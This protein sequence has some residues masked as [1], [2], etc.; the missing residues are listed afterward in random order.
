MKGDLS[1]KGYFLFLIILYG[2]AAGLAASGH[3][4]TCSDT[5]YLDTLLRANHIA[6]EATRSTKPL[7]TSGMYADAWRQISHAPDP[8]T[9]PLA[10][11]KAY[12][13]RAYFAWFTSYSFVY[14]GD[15]TL[16]LNWANRGLYWQR[17][18]D[19]ALREAG[20]V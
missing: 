15:K 8:C 20:V 14:R 1:W 11:S 3:A 10:R 16:A 18:A 17:L 7:E 9:S 6:Y 4:A 12:L 5:K 13:T 19:R 2:I